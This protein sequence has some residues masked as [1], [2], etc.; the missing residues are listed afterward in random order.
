VTP[1]REGAAGSSLSIHEQC[2]VL[3]L[4][5]ST[6]YE[7]LSFAMERQQRK[8]GERKIRKGRAKIVLDE[9]LDHS[10][11]GYKK[12]SRHLKRLKYEWA[13][14]KM[15]RILYHELS[16]KGQKPVFRTTRPGKRPYGK[17]PYL[18]RN[19][20]ARFVN[21]IWATDITYISTPQGMRYFTA[22]IDLF[23]RKI[24][25]WRLSDTMKV[26][27]CIACVREAIERYGIP[28][29]FNT[30]CGSQYTSEAFVKLL[31]SY[32]I[33]ISMDG[34]GRCKDNIFVERTWRT[35]KYE[36]IFLRDYNS[37]QKLRDSLGEFVK[38]FNGERIHQSLEYK[39][40]DEVYEQG[41]FPEL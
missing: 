20:T 2:R 3:G 40:P 25:S 37:E 24:L 36:W 22:V 38:F 7:Q 17:F 5:R 33:R 8:E 18:L 6:Y 13:G 21:E 29:I 30:D 1:K 9:W 39:T 23:S 35:L 15:I 32:R 11:Y 28:A 12:M 31:L 16:I 14:E 19:R 34:V 10:C 4:A 41:T 26:D 27:F